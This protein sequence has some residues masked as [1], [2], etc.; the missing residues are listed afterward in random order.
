MSAVRTTGCATE[1]GTVGRTR[2]RLNV[3]AKRSLFLELLLCYLNELAGVPSKGEEPNIAW[4]APRQG[5]SACL[6]SG[7]VDSKSTGSED[8]D[9]KGQEQEDEAAGPVGT[10]GA[11]VIGVVAGAVLDMVFETD[12][13]LAA[14]A[15]E[16]ST[17]SA[18]A[19]VT[20]GVVSVFGHPVDASHQW[21]GRQ[22]YIVLCR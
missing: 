4:E 8:D 9:G 19:H 1:V 16:L 5:D 2:C 13:P 22:Y 11:V 7:E 20:L 3:T 14:L 15:L 12:E 6:A 21:R 10:R 18:A 17:V